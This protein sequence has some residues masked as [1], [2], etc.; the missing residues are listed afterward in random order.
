[1]EEKA[2]QGTLHGQRVREERRKRNE[3]RIVNGYQLKHGQ[4]W[5]AGLGFNKDPRSHNKC[6]PLTFINFYLYLDQV[7]CGRLIK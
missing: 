6:I 5:Y 1:M 4:P 2:V 3:D 7:A